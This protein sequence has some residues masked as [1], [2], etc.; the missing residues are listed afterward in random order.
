MSKTDKEQLQKLAEGFCIP[1][2]IADEIIETSISYDGARR[3]LLH[4]ETRRT[5]QR[6]QRIRTSSAVRFV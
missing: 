4:P 1:K 3:K 2:E 6:K 5:T